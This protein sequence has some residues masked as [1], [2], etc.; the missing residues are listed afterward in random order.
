MTMH[1]AVS[2]WL[3]GP[4]SGANRRLLSLLAHTGTQLAPGE[5]ITVL[6]RPDFT[7]PQL[8]RIEWRSV[9]IPG[10]P[11][12]RRVLAERRLLPGC[13]REL[14]ASLCDHGFLPLPDLPV[15]VCLLLHDLRAS[16][17]FTRWP[18]WLALSVLR[19]SCARAAAVVVPSNWT[20][21]R[22]R[23]LAPGTAPRV[24]HNGVELPAP[25]PR[26]LP[27]SPPGPL[28][29]RGYLLHVGHLE[30]RKNL[31]LLVQALA[32]VPI[33]ERPE[34]WLAG[35]DAGERSRLEGL[36]ARLQ[37][38]AFVRLLGVVADREL[39]ALYGHARAVVVPSVY[40]GF[41]LCA[42]EGL[43]HGRPVLA[44]Q[45][46]S[47]PEVVG[48]AG[49]LLPPHDVQAWAA[50]IGAT[51]SDDSAAAARRRAQAAR[52]GWREAAAALL[53]TWRLCHAGRGSAPGGLAASVRP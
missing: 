27:E 26:S 46:T 5:R 9:R 2:G 18:R 31:A 12:W 29:P 16:E 7:P 33:G 44:S 51:R 45:A 11:P 25:S 1:V 50:A 14:G 3:L 28:P 35:R 20:A 42:L 32:C 37:C 23:T 4:P 47:L 15:P 39:D 34:L 43:A 38:G 40:E 24:V 30:A 13:L 10:A 17:G 53:E 8:P 36:A 6:H 49:Q 21:Q 22:L 52:F 41:G 19:R 48:T